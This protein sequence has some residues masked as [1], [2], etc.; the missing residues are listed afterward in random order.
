MWWSNPVDNDLATTEDGWPLLLMRMWFGHFPALFDQLNGLQPTVI[1]LWGDESHDG[2]AEAFIMLN[3]FHPGGSSGMLYMERHM[4][5]VPE[6]LLF[7]STM[8]TYV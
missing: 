1:K 2:I 7:Q 8:D 5:L 6:G 3:L 4:Q